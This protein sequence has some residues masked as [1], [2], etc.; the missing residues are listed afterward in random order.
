VPILTKFAANFLKNQQ[1]K[2]SKHS[3]KFYL[4]FVPVFIFACSSKDVSTIQ[5]TI[6]GIDSIAEISL[7][8]QEF[9][10]NILHKTISVKAKKPTFNFKVDVL[11]EPTFFQLHVNSG[12]NGVVVLLIEPKESV[13]IDVDLNDFVNYELKGSESSLKIQTLSKRLAQTLKSLDSLSALRARANSVS[14]KQVLLN[15][16][17]QVIESQRAYS[18]KF[19]WDNPMSRANVMA[20]YQQYGKDEFVFDRQ[21][22]IQL[23]KVVATSIVSRYPESSYAKGMLRDIKNMEKIVTNSKIQALIESAESSLPEIALPNPKGDTIK[24]SSL[25]GKVILLDFWAS[26]NQ[27]SLLENR[28][29]LEVYKRFKS[30]GLEIYQVS[31]DYERESWMAGIQS[32][33]LPWINVSELT[34]DVSIAAQNYNVTRIPANYLI[35]RNFEIVGKDLFGKDL[36]QM[37]SKTL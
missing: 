30:Q 21:E 17:Y 25:K 36:V 6:Q 29:L 32:A 24:L 2:Q 5:G 10:R 34:K 13:T 8:K 23:F 18:T 7:Y 31:F 1:M 19:I 27:N 35:N 26:F 22:D 37:I 15:E 28:E 9:D 20:L 33:N 14:H 11:E 16:Y 12:K 4:F 3:L